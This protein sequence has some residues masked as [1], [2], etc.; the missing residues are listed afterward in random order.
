VPWDYGTSVETIRASISL[1]RSEELAVYRLALPDLE[2]KA[3]RLDLGERNTV[4]KWL[5]G[6]VD[7]QPKYRRSE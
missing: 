5:H 6:E 1:S 2:P 3:V 7:G 4:A